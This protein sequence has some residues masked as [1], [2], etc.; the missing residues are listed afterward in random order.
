MMR[1]L[2]D[3]ELDDFTAGRCVRMLSDNLLLF[4]Q[5]VE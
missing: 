3:F 5:V 4:F 1:K 2:D